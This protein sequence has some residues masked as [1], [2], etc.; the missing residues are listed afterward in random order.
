NRGL[1]LW[2]FKIGVAMIVRLALFLFLLTN[3]IFAA[4]AVMGAAD[5]RPSA[6]RP[7]G[8]RGDGTG[9]FPGATPP[10]TWSRR[11]ISG[12]TANARYQSSRPKSNE[13]GN[14]PRLELGI[15][16]D[17]LVLGPFA[18]EHPVEDIE[19]EFI[20]NETSIEPDENLKTGELTW[21]AV[22]ASIDTQ[23]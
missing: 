13:P 8:W 21:K 10:I 16:K 12:A 2:R 9:R 15:V 11:V 6:E 5:Y 1:K 17:W 19:K 3:G 4:D 7:M 23:S 14:A 20:A 18:S 22:H